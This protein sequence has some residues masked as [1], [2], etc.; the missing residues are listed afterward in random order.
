MSDTDTT[1]QDE[2][3]ALAAAEAGYRKAT[4]AAEPA[5]LE[6]AAE[7]IESDSGLQAPANEVPTEPDLSAPEPSQSA[8]DAISEQLEALKAQVRE[9]KS[10]G[11]DAEAVRR[12]H[13]EIGNINRTLKQ[14]QSQKD[15]PADEEL[16]AALKGMEERA[17]EFPEILGD[18]VKVIK[19]LQQQLAA[20]SQ[21]QQPD[22]QAA[23]TAGG[24]PVEEVARKAAEQ[25][26][27]EVI[28]EIHPDRRAVV[29]SRDFKAWFAKQPPES[30]TKWNSSWNPV[31]VSECLTSY[32]A[33][34]AALKS[35]QSRLESAVG[36]SGGQQRGVPSTLSNEEAA[37]RG[38]MRTARRF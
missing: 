36:P 13:G 38:Y 10:S 30:Q 37:M 3:A 8:Q 7:P 32:K 9:L 4:G 28:D 18:S 16:A 22:A 1:S 11:A 24:E 33:H 27:V 26:L 17:A 21:E 34:V 31:V 5:P 23:P 6:A 35:K 15:A 25:K 12:M 14:L 20:K 29:E 2:A 19:H